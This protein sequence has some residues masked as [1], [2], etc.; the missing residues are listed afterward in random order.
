MN[1]PRCVLSM[2]SLYAPGSHG[3]IHNLGI[4]MPSRKPQQEVKP[5]YYTELI[6]RH[7]WPPNYRPHPWDSRAETNAA[8]ARANH[9][10]AAAAGAGWGTGTIPMPNTPK[11]LAPAWIGA[12]KYVKPVLKGRG[13]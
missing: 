3:A 10:S 12:P 7:N 11:H 5:G 2:P 6:V 13:E 8:N 1:A 9:A 4:T